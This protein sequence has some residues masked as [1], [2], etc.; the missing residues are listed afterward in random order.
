V[1]KPAVS[2]DPVFSI[3][4][5]QGRCDYSGE[6][7]GRSLKPHEVRLSPDRQLCSGVG[8]PGE[9]NV[10]IFFADRIRHRGSGKLGRVVIGERDG[11]FDAFR[12]GIVNLSTNWTSKMRA[13][14]R[15]YAAKEPSK[16]SKSDNRL[17]PF[18]PRVL[19]KVGIKWVYLDFYAV[20]FGPCLSR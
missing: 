12:P 18:G 8:H 20:I 14:I 7:T 19:P 2:S 17:S 9:F 4:A 1:D 16:T 5:R 15:T 10:D 6:I 13:V 11:G 3:I